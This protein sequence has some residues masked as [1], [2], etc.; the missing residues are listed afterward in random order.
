[1]YGTSRNMTICP[2]GSL[3]LNSLTHRVW[4]ASR[5]F[6]RLSAVCACCLHPITQESTT[7][8]FW[9]QVILSICMYQP[10]SSLPD[11][12]A[13]RP[14]KATNKHVIEVS[15]GRTRVNLLLTIARPTTSHQVTS[16]KLI[17][18]SRARAFVIRRKLRVP[19]STLSG[20]RYADGSLL[21]LP[22]VRGVK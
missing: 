12:T 19:L 22:R 2:G 11:A 9:G 5:K 21:L 8:G 16:E 10:P 7:T 17:F 20:C 1:M 6:R 3:H 18:F 13:G 14:V 4:D 15:R